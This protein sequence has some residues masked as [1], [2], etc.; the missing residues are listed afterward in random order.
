MRIISNARDRFALEKNEQVALEA[1]LKKLNY[2]RVECQSTS[3]GDSEE[4]VD[5]EESKEG[6]ETKKTRKKK[7]KEEIRT[8]NSG[9]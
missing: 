8:D 6:S 4:S 7:D 9:E 3:C 1:K 2:G 5:K